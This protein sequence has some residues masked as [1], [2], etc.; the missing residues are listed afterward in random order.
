MRTQTFGF[1]GDGGQRLSG[2]LDLPSGPVTSYVIFAH[3]FTYTRDSIAA[4]RIARALP[5]EALASSVSTSR[6]GVRA[7]VI[8][9]LMDSAR[10]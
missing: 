5:P 2:R 8:S 6:D 3:C 4:V 9:A 1:A 10:R 7:E